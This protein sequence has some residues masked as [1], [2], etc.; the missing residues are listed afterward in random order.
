M[1]MLLLLLGGPPWLPLPSLAPRTTVV[2][3]LISSSSPSESRLGL[4]WLL[5]ESVSGSGRRQDDASREARAAHAEKEAGGSGVEWGSLSS[6]ACLPWGRLE[7]APL[8]ASQGV[9]M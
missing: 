5:Q 1:M 3:G 8:H 9:T 2:L 7:G 6:R 4:E